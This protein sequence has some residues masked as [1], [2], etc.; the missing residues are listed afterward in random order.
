MK[1]FITLLA[2]TASVAFCNAQSR[3]IPGMTTET[4]VIQTKDTL[5]GKQSKEALLKVPYSLWY[6]PNRENYKPNPAT[7]T[8]LKNHLKDVT[9]TVFMGTWCEDSQ[10]QV[11]GFYKILEALQFDN[12]NVT[13]IAVDKNKKTPEQFEKGLN[14]TNVPTF[15]FYKNGKELHRIVERPI[16]TLEKDMLKI[17]SGQSYKHAYQN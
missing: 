13:L 2:L 9:I 7:V 8:E 14:V 17:L 3:Q 16:E 1:T 11:P 12:V 4:T 5:I 6:T 10:Q 15:I